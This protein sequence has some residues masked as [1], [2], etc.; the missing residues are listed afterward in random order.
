M[1]VVAALLKLILPKLGSVDE[2]C[3]KSPSVGLEP[4]YT[5]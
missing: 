1:V 4:S 5:L 3:S 2:L